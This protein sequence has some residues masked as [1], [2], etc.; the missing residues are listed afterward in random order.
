VGHL[1][2]VY[3]LNN[4][5]KIFKYTPKTL[6]KRLYRHNYNKGRFIVGL[7]QRDIYDTFAWTFLK[8]VNREIDYIEQR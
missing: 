1:S 7:G 4:A 8:T 6:A 2:C 5:L 3:S